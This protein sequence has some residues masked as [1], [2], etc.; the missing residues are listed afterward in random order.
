MNSANERDKPGEQVLQN[1]AGPST[2]GAIPIGSQTKD[3]TVEILH[4]SNWLKN[5]LGKTCLFSRLSPHQ[6]QVK[7]SKTRDDMERR[8][9]VLE[10]LEKN[11]I[12][13]VKKRFKALTAMQDP[14]KPLI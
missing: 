1:D 14:C 2:S 9:L 3:N 13:K 4:F 8:L 5:Y 7:R 10:K 12:F 11:D 6:F